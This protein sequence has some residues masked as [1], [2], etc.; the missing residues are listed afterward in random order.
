MFGGPVQ[1]ADVV[2]VF[3]R[4]VLHGSR[5][6]TFLTL[7]LQDGQDSSE[8][9]DHPVLKPEHPDESQHLPL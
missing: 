4:V 3:R 9:T 5:S 2:A 1:L 6:A 8:F 7:E